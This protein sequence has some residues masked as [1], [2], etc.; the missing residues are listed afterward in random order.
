MKRMKRIYKERRLYF[1]Q[2]CDRCGRRYQSFKRKRIKEGLCRKCRRI[3]PDQT[4]LFDETIV[5]SEN[6]IKNIDAI[7]LGE[8][9]GDKT[10]EQVIKIE[11]ETKSDIKVLSVKVIECEVSPN[12]EH[13]YDPED[14]MCIYCGGSQV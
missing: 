7:D 11:S 3:N 4:S 2:A 13:E 14:K 6:Q 9:Q 10:V 1:S 8:K 12:G 5:L